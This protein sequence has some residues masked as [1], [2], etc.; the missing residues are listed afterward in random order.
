[1]NWERQ[2]D[3]TYITR[4]ALNI[5]LWVGKEGGHWWG[6]GHWWGNYIIGSAR[7]MWD[8]KRAATEWIEGWYGQWIKEEATP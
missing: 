3:G 8:T 6:K 7:T 4:P 2:A 1:M 5:V